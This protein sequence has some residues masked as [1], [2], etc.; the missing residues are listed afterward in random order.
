MY[1]LDFIKQHRAVIPITLHFR[2]NIQ[3]ISS[4]LHKVNAV[5]RTRADRYKP[6]AYRFAGIA[7]FKALFGCYNIYPYTLHTQPHCKQQQKESLTRTGH[8]EYR[9]ISVAVPCSIVMVYYYRRA[10]MKIKPVKYSFFVAHFKGRKRKQRRG[11]RG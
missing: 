6:A 7:V 1:A 10:V 8:S 4:Y 9:H 11:G 2:I 5:G 3:R